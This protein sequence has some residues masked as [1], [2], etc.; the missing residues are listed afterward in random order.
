MRV[1][2]PTLSFSLVA[3]LALDASAQPKPPSEAELGTVE[4]TGSAGGSLPKL[5]ILPLDETDSET[6]A[7]LKKD[8]DRLGVWDVIEPVAM[9]AGPFEKDS[10]LDLKAFKAKGI[11]VVVRARKD[12]P[13]VR[14]EAWLSSSGDDPLVKHAIPL[15]SDPRRATHALADKLVSALTGRTGPFDSHLAFTLRTAK[16]RQVFSSDFDGL[17]K[18]AHGNADDTALSPTFGPNDEVWFTIS[19]SYDPFKLVHGPA[20]VELPTGKPGSVLSVSFSP[21]RTKL[22]IAVMK[23]EASKL[24]R[25]N[26]DATELAPVETTALPNRPVL[27]PLGKLAWVASGG[28]TQRVYVDGHAVSPAGFH[29]SAPTFCDSPQGLLVVFTVGVGS[30]A[31]LLATDTSGGNLRRLTQ[32]HGSNAYPACSPD[33]R[34]VAFFS[35]GANG[36]SPGLYTLP[37]ANPTRIRRL[38]DDHGDSLAWAR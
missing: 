30:G 15:G 37:I 4:V 13:V 23:D 28:G 29:A 5:A 26:A 19:K 36:K 32:G 3:A 34:L 22:A 31:D 6:I 33:G 8:L 20:A 1:I 38:T 14:A 27:G 21:D 17:G 10:P 18:V 7:T 11:S 9:P 12:G 24:Y 16:G 25:G 35:T 2:L